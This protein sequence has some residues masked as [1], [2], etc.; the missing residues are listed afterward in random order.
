MADIKTL[1]YITMEEHMRHMCF[2][3]AV[4][5][6]SFVAVPTFLDIWWNVIPR[7]ATYIQSSRLIAMLNSTLTA[8][9]AAAAAA[10]GDSGNSSTTGTTDCTGVFQCLLKPHHRGVPAAIMGVGAIVILLTAFFMLTGLVLYAATQMHANRS[11]AGHRR[12]RDAP[13]DLEDQKTPLFDSSQH[14]YSYDGTKG[15]ST[16]KDKDEDA[17]LQ[18]MYLMGGMDDDV[19]I[20]DQD[21]IQWAAQHVEEQKRLHELLFQQ[22]E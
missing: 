12:R 19:K 21:L 16:E 15:S 20:G 22:L 7:S 18:R 13:R 8:A 6:F 3:L 9:T 4:V 2:V 11:S 17:A 5:V 1:E 10:V 14:Y